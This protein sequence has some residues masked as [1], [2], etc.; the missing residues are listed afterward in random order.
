MT[1]ISE[2][3]TQLTVNAKG[4]KKGLDQASKDASSFASKATKVGL[5]TAAAF[6]T[7]ALGGVTL[8][9]NT[10]L[11]T[12][13]KID[14]L[15]DTAQKLNVAF[16]DLE[17]LNFA[18]KLAAADPSVIT[19][20]LKKMITTFSQLN[21]Q[22]FD[23]K[24]KDLN[25]TFKEIQGLNP[26]QQYQLVADKIKELPTYTQQAEAAIKVFGKSGIDQL[27]LLRSDIQGAIKE[28]EDLGLGISQAG[29][30][31]VGGFKDSQDKFNA[32]IG[33]FKDQVTVAL[34]PAFTAFNDKIIESVKEFGGLRNVATAFASSLL[35]GLAFVIKGYGAFLSVLDQ[36]ELK[37]LQIS[38]IA[39]SFGTAGGLTT[40]LSEKFGIT[41]AAQT[42]E[43]IQYNINR[44]AQIKQLQYSSQNGRDSINAILGGIESLQQSINKAGPDFKNVGTSAAD[45]VNITLTSDTNGIL[46]AVINSA[47]YNSSVRAAV[48]TVAAEE[49]RR[50]GR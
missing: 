16:G 20:G 2:L 4:F 18:G 22:D 42:D 24:F 17:K 41:T 31:G 23:K 30:D 33:S 27:V 12:A 32:I 7:I 5:V 37:I 44:D 40:A 29:A 8:L 39:D 6:G 43:Q 19:A 47:G 35:T 1:I 46:K 21:E 49:A 10:I 9:A 38:K 11:D 26:A 25:L 36:I 50:V 13:D 14:A 15:S 45:K 34:I 3:V 28:F 48:A